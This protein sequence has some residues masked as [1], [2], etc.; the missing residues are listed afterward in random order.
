MSKTGLTVLVITKNEASN[1]SDCLRSVEWADNIV[2]VDAMSTDETTEIA[3][4]YTE[5]IFL[6]EWLGFGEAKNFGLAHC[7][8]EW[9][10]WLDAD[11]RVTPELAKEIQAVMAAN[12]TTA[13]YEIARRAY[14]LGKWI[15]H[16]GW[17][18]GYVTRLFRK[19]QARFSETPVH[20]KLIVEGKT[21][22]LQNDLLHFTDNDLEHYFQKFNAYTSLAAEEIAQHGRRAGFVDMVIRP[23]F[24]FFRMYILKCGF[25]DGFH[26]LLL[27]TLSAFYVF[28]KYAKVWEKKI[29]IQT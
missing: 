5:N 21:K 15:R 28:V 9:V 11:E 7:I 26:G 4:Q 6:H 2:V 18:P 8:N 3:R 22:R 12:N 13:A 19:S 23:P 24:T 1:I 16:C 17:Y 29:H 27:C 10:L 20:E 14:F 25:L